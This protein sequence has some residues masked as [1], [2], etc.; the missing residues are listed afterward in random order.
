MIR[1]P[2][3]ST[4]FPYT[5]LFRSLLPPAEASEEGVPAPETASLFAQSLTPEQKTVFEALRADEAVF[6]D[7]ICGSVAL[8]QPRVLA[9]LLELEMNGLVRQLPGKE[10]HPQTVISGIGDWGLET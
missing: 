5:T 6:V 8:P 9:T 1:R 2:P 7:S 3:R 4:L 10:F